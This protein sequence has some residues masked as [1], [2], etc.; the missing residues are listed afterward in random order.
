MSTSGKF[1]LVLVVIIIGL[2]MFPNQAIEML[3][4]FGQLITGR[5]ER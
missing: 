5:L 2:M 1:M 4:L 3:R